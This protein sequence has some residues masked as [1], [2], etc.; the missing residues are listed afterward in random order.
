MAETN[1]T[2]RKKRLYLIP[3]LIP[4]LGLAALIALVGW[5]NTRNLPTRVVTRFVP[6]EPGEIVQL[7][8]PERRALQ[9]LADR[10]DGLVVWSSNRSGNHEL[11]LL[12][13]ATGEARQLTD[14]PHVDFASRFSP[15]GE[16]IVFA[17]SRP[18]WVSFRN[19]NEWDVWLMRSDGTEERRIAERGYHP[20]WTGDGA[21]VVFHRGTQVIRFDLASGNEELLWDGGDVDLGDPELSPSGRY[22]A[23]SIGG[24]GAWIEDLRDG[25]RVNI[26][27]G[28]S[29]QTTWTPD[30]D[31]I[32]WMDAS[33]NGG[34]RIMRSSADGGA[35]KVFMDLPGERSHEYFPVLSNDGNWM[36][37]GASAEG[38]E[39]DRA[40]YE[41]Y[42]WEVGTDPAEATRLT[43][44]TGN[45]QW[46]DIWVQP[47]RDR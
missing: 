45:D 36:V 11:Y 6:P 25:S 8:R 42:L 18:E 41:I 37:W 15:D 24:G 22:L 47:R 39:H 38:H 26:T 31:A 3:L 10:L 12:E 27:E 30:G 9:A 21:G 4:A 20:R 7:R 46:P 23:Y 40:D 44:H 34:T 19:I 5:D 33:G 1:R 16:H 17:R 2:K 29:C 28:Q 13:T 32:L 14:D 35:A 43:F